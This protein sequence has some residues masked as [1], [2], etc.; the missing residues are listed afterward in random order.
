[1]KKHNIAI[2]DYII[3]ALSI[4]ALIIAIISLFCELKN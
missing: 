4:A 2:S 1:M 3:R